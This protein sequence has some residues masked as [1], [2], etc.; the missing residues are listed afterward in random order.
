MCVILVAP[1]T[2]RPS[3]ETLEACHQANPHGM[4]I[5]WRDGAKVRFFKSDHVSTINRLAR[6]AKGWVVIHF[7]IASV[8][9]V[10]GELRH[11]FPVT[12]RSVLEDNGSTRRVLFQNGTWSGWEAA[13]RRAEA[14]GHVRPRGRMSDTRAAAWLCSIRGGHQWLEETGPSRWVYFTG[15][16]L[17]LVGNWYK[18]DEIY[19]SNLYWKRCEDWSLSTR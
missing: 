12:S 8:G 9:G 6:A 3:L 15:K 5:A 4:G 17:H 19:F 18:Q 14:E 16:R 7:R 1:P 13:V 11:P 10:C 2:V